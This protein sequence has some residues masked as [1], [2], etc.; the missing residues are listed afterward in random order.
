MNQEKKMEAKMDQ[1]VPDLV[2]EQSQGT[3]GKSDIDTPIDTD[4]LSSESE[5][6]AKKS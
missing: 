4:S 5:E 2:P 3:F 1:L 6:E